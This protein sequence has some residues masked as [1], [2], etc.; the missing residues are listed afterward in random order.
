M[1]GLRQGTCGFTRPGGRGPATGRYY[2]FHINRESMDSL[3]FNRADGNE[4]TGIEVDTYSTGNTIRVNIAR[5][6][7]KPPAGVH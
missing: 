7:C 2:D 5:S 3:S 4:T 6:R 1:S